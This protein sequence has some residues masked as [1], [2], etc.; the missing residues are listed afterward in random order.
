M[1]V[2]LV[3]TSR[4]RK[5]NTI[6]L[7]ASAI[8]SAYLLPDILKSFI[9]E[10]LETE[11]M[12][13]QSGFRDIITGLYHWPYRGDLRCRFGRYERRRGEPGMHSL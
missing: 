5:N 3:E 8:L 9:Q 7:G 1:R 4:T 6:Y 2:R 12:I 13:S 11:F 10:H